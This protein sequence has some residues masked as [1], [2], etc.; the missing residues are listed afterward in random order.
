MVLGCSPERRTTS[1]AAQKDKGVLMTTYMRAAATGFLLCAAV[2][3]TSSCSSQTGV[4]PR[5]SP[6]RAA[7]DYPVVVDSV[8][9]R[10][11]VQ[12]YMATDAQLQ[13]INAARAKIMDRCLQRFNITKLPAATGANAFGPQS[14]TDRRYGIFDL[15]IA[16]KFGYG[17][18]LRDPS[19]QPRPAQPNLGP[20]GQTVFTG[21]GRSQINGK[22][23]PEGGCLGETDRALDAHKPAGADTGLPQNLSF[24]SFEWSR[25]EPRVVAAFKA[26]STCMAGHQ[27]QYRDPLAPPA[28]SRFTSTPS[29]GMSKLAI[30]TATTDIGCKGK[31]NLVGIW[32]GVESDYQAEQIRTHAAAFKAAK[33]AVSARVAIARATQP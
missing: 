7:A 31:T 27:Y 19:L 4:A 10:L 12:D 32:F 16:A 20:D 28:D 18:G 22:N 14:L 1:V 33:D 9:L 24:E 23:I 29:A 11:P 26:W 15:P 30:N 21:E 2:L 25:H 13:T 6:S 8:H 3:A 17:M 5:P